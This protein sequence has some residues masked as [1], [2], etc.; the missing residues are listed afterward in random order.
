MVVAAKQ[1]GQTFRWPALNSPVAILKRP[2]QSDSEHPKNL[3]VAKFTSPGGQPFSTTT[4][5]AC[6]IC[7]AVTFYIA[8]DG[9]SLCPRH[10]S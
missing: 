4:R 7:G 5:L 9:R 8:L 1:G 3:N 10:R 6:E 2:V